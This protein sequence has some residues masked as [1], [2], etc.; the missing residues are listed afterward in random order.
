M[1]VSRNVWWVR[2]VTFASS[3]AR[4]PVRMSLCEFF[5]RTVWAFT[6][7][8]VIFGLGCV[9]MAGVVVAVSPFVGGHWLWKRHRRHHPVE[10]TGL[11]G[12]VTARASAFYHRLCPLIEWEEEK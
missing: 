3:N 7:F 10:P 6:V 11:V 4:L 12:M 5:W 8:P 2:W 1:R 9:M